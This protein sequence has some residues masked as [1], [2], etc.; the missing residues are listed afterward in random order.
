MIFV[1][2]QLLKTVRIPPIWWKVEKLL[3]PISIES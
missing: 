1:K 3:C 2:L